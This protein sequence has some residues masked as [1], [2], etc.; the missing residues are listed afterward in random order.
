MHLQDEH[1][2][3]IFFVNEEEIKTSLGNVLKQN[4]LNTENVVDIVYQQQAVFK[5]R[6]VTRCTR[7]G[8]L[9]YVYIKWL[10]WTILGTFLPLR[11]SM[12][13]HAEAVISVSFSPDG[14]HL[15]SG[16]GDT[17][18]RFWD[19]HTQTPHHTCKGLCISLFSVLHTCCTFNITV[20]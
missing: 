10:N 5:V 16:S 4:E 13:G 12:P 15:A 19:I 9:I 3:F 14:Q 6:A 17:T 18:V 7:Y 1:T 20:L 2:P 11:S 8:N